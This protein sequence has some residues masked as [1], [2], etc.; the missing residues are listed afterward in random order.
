MEE[1]YDTY[2]EVGK[3]AGLSGTNLLR[4][5]N[6]MTFRWADEEKQHCHCGYAEEWAIRFLSGRE[7]AASDMVGQE[8]LRNIDQELTKHRR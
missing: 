7:Y 8:V 4:Y 1:I 2:A 5:I 6:Y 3:A